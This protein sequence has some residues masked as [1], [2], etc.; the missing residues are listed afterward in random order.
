MKYIKF[1]VFLICILLLIP[2]TLHARVGSRVQGKIVDKETGEPISGATVRL[3]YCNIRG[4]RFNYRPTLTNMPSNAKHIE[5]SANGEFRFEDQNAGYYFITVIKDG[6]AAV[7]P[8]FYKKPGVLEDPVGSAEK[9][10]QVE[11]F[12]LNEGKVKHFLVRMEKEAVLK[13]NVLRK[14]SSGVEPVDIFQVQLEHSGFIEKLTGFIRPCAKPGPVNPFTPKYIVTGEGFQ[15]VYFK[16]G[17]VNLTIIP[18]GYLYRTFRDIQLEFGEEKL[19]EWVLDY[20]KGPVVFGVVKRKDTGKPVYRANLTIYNQDDTDKDIYIISRTN[21]DG[22]YWLGG[23]EPGVY[24][25]N[26]D[27]SDRYNKR[28]DYKTTLKIAPDSMIEINKDF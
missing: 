19:I 3:F 5:T 16:K 11:F 14:T 18:D 17:T 10:S 1:V 8:F 13:V 26:I 4:N 7:G 24:L 28:Y 25:F 2:A 23:M 27:F 15:T 22:K 12:F 20:T 6:Y 9:T 21:R